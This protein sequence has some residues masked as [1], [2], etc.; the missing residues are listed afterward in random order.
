[1]PRTSSVAA[2]SRP[3]AE[4]TPGPGELVWIL[5]ADAS[6]PFNLV[7]ALRG[8]DIETRMFATGRDLLAQERPARL[9]AIVA[10]MQVPDMEYH[11]LLDRLQARYPD[12][13]VIVIT[14]CPDLEHAVRVFREGAFE[15]LPEPFELAEAI[16][17]IRRACQQGRRVQAME[18][19]PA[20]TGS[21]LIGSA[22]AMHDV[23]RTIARLS[24]S[25]ATVLV[26]GESGTGKERVARALHQHGPR[27]DRPFI[28]LNMAAMPPELMEAELF[29]HEAG[30]L[31]AAPARRVGRFEQANGGTLFL[32]EIGD[33]PP[34]IQQRLLRVLAEGEFFPVGALNPVKVD[35]RIVAATHQ[36]LEAQTSAGRFREDLYHRLSAVR[37]QLPPLRERRQDIP[38][39]LRHFLREAARELKLETRWLRPEVEDF[40]CGLDW[41]GNVRQLENACRWITATGVGREVFMQDLPPELLQ[42]GEPERFSPAMADQWTHLLRSWVLQRLRSGE[43]H[44][45]RET[46]DLAEAILIRTALELTH[47]RREEAARLLGYGRNTVSRKI[48]ELNLDA[49]ASGALPVTTSS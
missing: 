41:P 32:D 48:A 13:P 16:A 21:D 38:L 43:Q 11:E 47:G 30:A 3:A 25:H 14:P 20:H 35:V 37:I 26:Q 18:P 10:D 44:V 5:D 36:N 49:N 23:F 42:S 34:V 7:K 17:L 29:G 27:A 45:A 19:A 46:V 6:I 40:L 31:P 39:L 28:A 15:Y 2:I 33:L 1:M 8:L 12:M 24:R 9:S 22:P 4:P